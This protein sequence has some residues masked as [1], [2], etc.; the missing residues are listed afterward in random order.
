VFAG[1]DRYEA[2]LMAEQNNEAQN[3][4]AVHLLDDGFQHLRL[5]RSVDIVLLTVEDAEDMLLPA[6]NLR[7][8]VAAAGEAHIV[9]IRE[10][11][12]DALKD[13]LEKL[14]ER[15][16]G[17]A[18]W[19]IRRSL[20]LLD[21]TEPALPTRPLAFCGIARP[22]N[23]TRMLTASRYEP[24]ETV[25]FADHHPYGDSDMTRLIDHARRIGANGFV[26]TEKDVV[27]ITPEMRAQLRDAGPLIVAQLKVELVGE[28][29]ALSQLV[30]MVGQLDRRKN[31]GRT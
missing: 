7:E 26:T 25:A 27:K 14:R 8:P 31:R 12:S 10:E 30:T 22:E 11:E 18:T 19:S 16:H 28:K 6:G 2:G 13:V 9:V 21:G 15:G 23:F 1:A 4:I 24:M 17:F 5:A 3:R 20:V 29:E